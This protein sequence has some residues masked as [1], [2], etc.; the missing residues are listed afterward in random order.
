MIEKILEP[1][2]SS[3]RFDHDPSVESGSS[4]NAENTERE[5]GYLAALSV[6]RKIL[7]RRKITTA[8]P[9]TYTNDL[10]QII[11]LNLW[12]WRAKYAKESGEME[13]AD[14]ERFAARSAFN[15]VN[16]QLLRHKKFESLEVGAQI[17][18][19]PQI[20][21]N[22]DAELKSLGLIFWQEICTLTVRHRRALLLHSDELIINLVQ[23]GIADEK[24]FVRMLELDFE[25]W[26][27]IC[28]RLPLTDFEIADLPMPNNCQTGARRRTADAAKSIKKARYEARV[29]LKKL[30]NR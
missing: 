25:T 7:R 10:F 21:G 16:R 13:N 6:V 19:E 26:L 8:V 30:L 2:F 5:G 17:A 12:N 14:W 11:A 23:S 28:Q 1:D 9:P 18:C 22:S 20:I 29:K 15:E 27:D 4:K 24:S 3:D